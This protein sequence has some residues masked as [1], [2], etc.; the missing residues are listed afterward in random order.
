M[1]Y[2]TGMGLIVFCKT[3]VVH[4]VLWSKMGYSVLE[5]INFFLEQMEMRRE[6]CLIELSVSLNNCIKTMLIQNIFCR[7]LVFREHTPHFKEGIEH[8]MVS[9]MDQRCEMPLCSENAFAVSQR[10]RSVCGF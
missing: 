6:M 7:P 8:V 1:Q 2:P 10:P 9:G 5:S 3:V 4:S